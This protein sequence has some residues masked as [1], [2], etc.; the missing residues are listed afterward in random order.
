MSIR[1]TI[2]LAVVVLACGPRA[3]SP[4]AS[5]LVEPMTAAPVEPAAT[6]DVAGQQWGEFLRYGLALVDLVNKSDEI[7]RI[8][9]EGA[10]RVTAANRA[11]F[12]NLT[13]TAAK[14]HGI[15]KTAAAAVRTPNEGNELRSRVHQVLQRREESMNALKRALDPGGTAAQAAY[16]RAKGAAAGAPL[17]VLAELYRLCGTMGADVAECSEAVGLLPE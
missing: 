13:D 17:A 7:A 11:S 10:G 5:P 4:R 1:L 3:A 14:N 9:S 16:D 6:S 12:Y 2:A 15:L 8:H